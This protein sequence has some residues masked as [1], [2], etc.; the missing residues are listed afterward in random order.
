MSIIGHSI[1][2]AVANVHIALKDQ[3]AGQA[4]VSDEDAKRKLRV[5][6]EEEIA[7]EA[8]SQSPEARQGKV[9]PTPRRDS[10]A[11]KRRGGSDDEPP[12]DVDFGH[13]DLLA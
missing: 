11:K 6:R 8:V 13:L 3:L 4:A 7:R 9:V 10:K 12:P 1:Q 2:T 5:E